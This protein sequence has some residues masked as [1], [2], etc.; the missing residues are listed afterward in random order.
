M[1]S[2]IILPPL[3]A[4]ALTMINAEFLDS[5]NGRRSFHINC[6]PFAGKMNPDEILDKLL[7]R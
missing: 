5:S 7:Q 1:P 3:L 4:R 2:Q 6:N